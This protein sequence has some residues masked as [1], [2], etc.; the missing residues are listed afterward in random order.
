MWKEG[1]RMKT[2]ETKKADKPEV[3]DDAMDAGFDAFLDSV[4]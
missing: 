1:K 2:Q 3:E 4:L